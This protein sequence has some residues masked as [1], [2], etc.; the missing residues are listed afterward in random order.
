AA[1]SSVATPRAHIATRHPSAA[2]PSAHALPMP[3]LAATTSAVL[4]LSPRSMSEASIE[5]GGHPALRPDTHTFP[6]R[7]HAPVQS[8]HLTRVSRRLPARPV[9]AFTR[10]RR[11][12]PPGSRDLL[13]ELRSIAADDV[14]DAQLVVA[15]HLERDLLAGAMPPQAQVQGL[16]RRYFLR[17]ERQD[18]VALLDTRPRAGPVGHHAGHDDPFLQRMRE[19]ADPRALGAT[20]HP[21]IAQQLLTVAL[22]EL[23][24]DGERV[25]RDLAQV[26]VDDADHVP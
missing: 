18:H 3:L 15:Q 5:V 9:R 20:Q 1:S 6:A 17:I 24:R 10:R 13:V 11:G 23:D 16:E 25:A 12:A 26:Q 7:H 8:T 19:H 2:S 22:V 14:Q 4:P 21:A